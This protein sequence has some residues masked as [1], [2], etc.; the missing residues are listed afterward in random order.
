MRKNKK[1]GVIALV[2]LVVCGM[3]IGYSILSRQLKI[4][5]TATIEQSFD[6]AITGIEKYT[7]TDEFVK[8]D[9]SHNIGEAYEIEKPSYTSATANFNV[10][11]G[12][13][14]YITYVVSIKNNGTMAA[15]FEKPQ[16]VKT[17][18]S[19]ITVETPIDLEN[20]ILEIGEEIKYIVTIK[21]NYKQ[22]LSEETTSNIAITINAKQV[23]N[24]DT[25]K[26]I[27]PYI[28]W[29]DYNTYAIGTFNFD[30]KGYA[31]Y[32]SVDDG[33]FEKLEMSGA[34]G[35]S[36]YFTSGDIISFYPGS[37]LNDGNTHT[38]KFKVQSL[39]GY[40]DP[41]VSNIITNFYKSS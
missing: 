15:A 31:L 1:I 2:L 8:S 13:D 21:Y 22:D 10:K 16:I 11:L 28:M 39:L 27:E 4:E 20:V 24:M 32:L 9:V 33:E 18:S 12:L 6:V 19:D 3:G 17:G 5:G 40:G 29:K 14:S 30:L 25:L 7:Y 23:Q 37:E 34:D 38:L 35:K 26:E 41:I 36:H